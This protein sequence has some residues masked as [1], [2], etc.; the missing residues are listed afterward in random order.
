MQGFVRGLTLI[1]SLG[2]LTL[3]HADDLPAPFLDRALFDAYGAPGA[4]QD[5]KTARHVKN[6]ARAQRNR[7]DDAYKAAKTACLEAFFVEACVNKHRKAYFDRSREL[8]SL[9]IAVDEW[10]REA[11]YKANQKKRETEQKAPHPVTVR[12]VKEKTGGV[13]LKPREVKPASIPLPV[14]PKVVK[15]ET[16][17]EM[18]ARLE[19]EREN[20]AL[21]ARKQA[22][23]QARKANAQAQAQ[24]RRERREAQQA[25][26]ERQQ[27]K[28]LDAQKRYEEKLENKDSKSGLRKYF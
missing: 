6:E 16:P 13:A 18:A 5:E 26:I 9:R 1:L 25:E 23:A 14:K 19:K 11:R 7:L 22:E 21:Y 24:A 2:W 28:R 20:E 10:L 4:I 27:A 8:H 12:E 17:E 3:A 15:T